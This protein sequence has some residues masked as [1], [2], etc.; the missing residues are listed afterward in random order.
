MGTTLLS[1]FSSFS[2]FLPAFSPLALALTLLALVATTA[3]LSLFFPS[4]WR[5]RRAAR[6][7]IPG[8]EAGHLL[9]GDL[10]VPVI[11]SFLVVKGRVTAADMVQVLR[12]AGIPHKKFQRL[13]Q[14][15]SADYR[16]HRPFDPCTDWPAY[17]FTDPA[18]AHEKHVRH[19]PDGMSQEGLTAYLAS[20]VNTPP[21]FDKSPWEIVVVN[22]YEGKPDSTALVLRLHHVLGD[23]LSL[24]GLLEVMTEPLLGKEEREAV[25]EEKQ[26]LREE[27][28]LGAALKVGVKQ[29]KEETPAGH[30]R[31][32]RVTALASRACRLLLLFVRMLVELPLNLRQHWYLPPREENLFKPRPL[33]GEKDIGWRSN[34]IDVARLKRVKDALGVKVND[35]LLACA[36]GALRAVAEKEGGGT[37]TEK[38]EEE[39]KKEARPVMTT[40]PESVAEQAAAAAEGPGGEPGKGNVP[41]S[42]RF[43]APMS[44]RTNLASL[45][46]L[47]NQLSVLSIPLPTGLGCRRHR[48][49]HIH[50]FMTEL[51]QSTVPLGMAWLTQATGYMPRGVLSW[52]ADFFCEKAT[53][54]LTNVPGPIHKRRIAGAEIEVG[55]FWS[56][57]CL[58]LSF[59]PFS[60]LLHIY[61]THIR[62]SCSLSRPWPRSVR[63]SHPPTHP[64]VSLFTHSPT[65]PCNRHGA[66]H[67]HLWRA[68]LGGDGGGQGGALRG[69][70]I[71]CCLGLFNL[72]TDPPTC[73]VGGG[74]F[75][76]VCAGV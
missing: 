16:E 73:A 34:H 18:F 10:N 38:E 28:M 67:V 11:H 58:M 41:E 57:V 72:S 31:G 66:V 37:S 50:G 68:A 55:K 12:G 22:E 59:Q 40:I 44:V 64:P 23:G 46:D 43:F 26:Q 35:V 13:K 7:Y 74:L 33:T 21:P 32:S 62:K 39:L 19:L 9:S 24:L 70:Y 20:V 25:M 51:K 27:R 71:V 69:R 8:N 29:Q 49:S 54:V 30:R 56:V 65:H 17:W 48:L 3:W 14:C 15:V 45:Q 36:T 4:V 5:G 42:I 53:G 47:D 75:G 52:Q 2:S 76:R 6:S 63:P 60:P 61:H 1:S